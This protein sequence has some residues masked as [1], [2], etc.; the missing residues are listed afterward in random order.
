MV[1]S[2]SVVCHVVMIAVHL[3]ALSDLTLLVRKSILP[4]EIEQ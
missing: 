2:K 3:I 4:I 1:Q